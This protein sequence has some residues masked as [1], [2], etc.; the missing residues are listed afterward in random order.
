M[1]TP[2]VI[3]RIQHRRGTQAQFDA[4]YH[5]YPGT[6]DN[7]LQPGEVALCTDTR[8]VFIGNINGEYLE[9]G[10]DSSNTILS[11]DGQLLHPLVIDLP[12]SATWAPIPALSFNP[13]PFFNIVYSL[14][15]SSED[16]WNVVGTTIARNGVLQITSL[17]HTTP[18]NVALTDICTE[19]NAGNY[20]VHFKAKYNSANTRIEIWYMHSVPTSVKFSTSS[21]SWADYSLPVQERNEIIQPTTETIFA[22]ELSTS[23]ISISGGAPLSAVRVKIGP[24]SS[25][26]EAGLPAGAIVGQLQLDIN[27][28]GSFSLSALGLLSPGHAE[29]VFEFLETQH[30][31]TAIVTL[32]TR[33]IMAPTNLQTTGTTSSSASFSWTASTTPGVVLYRI[34]SFPVAGSTENGV[35]NIASNWTTVA[36]GTTMTINGLTAGTYY[37]AVVAEDSRG[38]FYR[39]PYSNVVTVAIAASVTPVANFTYTPNTGQ[40]PVNVTFTNTSSNSTSFVWNFGDGTTSVLQNPQHTYTTA[41]TYSV[42][43]QATGPG[44]VN[45]VVKSN[46]IVVTAPVYNET[47]TMGSAGPVVGG[48]AA[49][50]PGTTMAIN[51]TGGFPSSIVTFSTSPSAGAITSVTLDA[52]GSFSS[53]IGAPFSV[54]G[55]YTVT[56]TFLATMHTRTT[57]VVIASGYNEIVSISPTTW[58]YGS[59]QPV[60]TVTGGMP[61]DTFSA[62]DSAGGGVIT[63]SLDA[64]GS[65]YNPGGGVSLSPVGA[66]TTTVV[67]SGT[68]HTRTYNYTVTAPA[69][70]E[71]VTITPNSWIYGV[72]L[73]PLITVTGGMPNDTFTATDSEGGGSIT[74]S[75]SATGTF[76]NNGPGPGIA[77]NAVGAHTTTVTFTNTGHVR[78]YGYTVTAQLYPESA[79]YSPS[80]IVV[81]DTTT[82][83]VTGTPNTDISVDG[84]AHTLDASGTWSST[85]A[86]IGAPG[87][88]N[89]GISF[90]ATGNSLTAILNIN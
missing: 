37:F 19:L 81:G 4:L 9:L 67:F 71:I 87:V 59:P 26:T 21:A 10:A 60:I 39:S 66:H 62:T 2:V 54:G 51:I 25:F 6:G 40:A 1:A 32:V 35:S 70:N 75:L 72:G 14:T 13:T 80:T 41:G 82:L 12:P 73:N 44:G 24:N 23:A 49:I 48:G 11:S 20:P 33:P 55:T 69:Y 53:A 47:F 57:T 86:Y 38:M 28:A 27:G 83:S 79:S 45:S 88:S 74:G 63:G 56:A 68:G 76:T 29:L 50:L 65:F 61:N 17:I 89:T 16:D 77:P 43:L 52:S 78:T 34:Y 64:T 18:A 58:V 42:S 22:Q 3:S 7:I 90:A 36:P 8:R 30:I 84:I 85:F 15:V 5:T 46:I 31:R